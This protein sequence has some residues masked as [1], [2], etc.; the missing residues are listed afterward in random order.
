MTVKQ[1]N[2]FPVLY[3]EA[4]EKEHF[5]ADELIADLRSEMAERIDSLEHRLAALERRLSSTES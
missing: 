3:R 5:T 1:Q 2:R 4:P